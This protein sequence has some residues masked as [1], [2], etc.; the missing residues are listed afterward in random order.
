[1]IDTDTD[2]ITEF[3]VPTPD[4]QPYGIV[5]GPDGTI[6]FT[7]AGANRIGRINPTTHVIQEFP[8]DS[9]GNDRGRGHRLRAR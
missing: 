1:M 2:Q 5:E 8:I 9:S 3:P 7:E 4:A 6:W